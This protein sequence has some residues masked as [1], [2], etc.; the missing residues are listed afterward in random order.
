MTAKLAPLAALTLW[1]LAGC[2]P[3][4]ALEAPKE[5]ITINL[6]VKIEHEIRIKVDKDLDQLFKDESDLF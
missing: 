2:S 5:P 4:V 3:R 6:N 1:F